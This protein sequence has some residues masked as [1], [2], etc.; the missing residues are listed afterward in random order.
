MEVRRESDGELCGF[1]DRCDRGWVALTVFGG[2]LGIETSEDEARRRVRDDG[3]SSL[4]ERWSLCRGGEH[5]RQVVCIQEAD[6]TGVTLALDSYSLPG[7][8]TM[9]VTRAQLDAGEWELTR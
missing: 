6:P 7:V 2:T 4:A 9:R 8:P 5:A 1:V 3:L